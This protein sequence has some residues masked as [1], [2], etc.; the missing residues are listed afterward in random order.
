VLN[1]KKSFHEA[2][3]DYLATC[4]RKRR[5]PDAPFKGSFNVRVPRDLHKRAAMFA[6]ENGKKLN[7]IVTEALERYL[8]TESA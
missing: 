2:V 5:A 7:A 8:D 3:E 1:L 4:A 6:A